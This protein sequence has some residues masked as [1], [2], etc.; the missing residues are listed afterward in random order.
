MS[1]APTDHPINDPVTEHE[2]TVVVL[3]AGGGT[4]MKSKTMKVLHQV[5][6]RSMIGHVLTAVRSVEPDRVVAVVGHQREEV[7]AH[8][9]ELVPDVVLAV[10]E[11]LDGTGGAVGV[12]MEARRR[13]RGPVVVATGDPPLLEGDSLRRFV[14]D[15]RAAEQVVSIL[16][17]IVAKPYGYGRILR[18]DEGDVEAIVEEKDAS[19][20]QRE[21]P[22]ISSGILAFDAAFLLSA[23]PRLTNDNAKGEFYLTD[24]VKIAR[25]DGLTV[26]AFP[27]DDVMQTEGANDREQLAAMGKELN[28]RIVS[29]WML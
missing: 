26:G 2:L 21:I 15:H 27:I 11:V 19:P 17:G 12:A 16:S 13:T 25:E 1:E 29:R 22:E 8:V 14:A 10:Q 3:A 9:R 28:R 23:L 24:T 5:G 20:A 18:N 7:G 6:G 4:R